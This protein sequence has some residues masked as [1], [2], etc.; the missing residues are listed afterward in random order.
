[1]TERSAR[2]ELTEARPGRYRRLPERT[3][4]EDTFIAVPVRPADPERGAFSHDEWLARN[5]WCGTLL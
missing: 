1:M 2:P 5:V 3:R 4:P